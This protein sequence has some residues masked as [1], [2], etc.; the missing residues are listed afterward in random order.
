MY[1]PE[2]P[3]EVPGKIASQELWLLV[4]RVMR[5]DEGGLLG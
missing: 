2:Q 3:R 4:G 1:K 5:V